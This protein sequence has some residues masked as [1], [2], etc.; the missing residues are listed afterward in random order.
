MENMFTEM[1]KLID[2]LEGLAIELRKKSRKERE[3]AVHVDVVVSN[4]KLL[5]DVLKK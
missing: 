5:M 2:E 1:R 4:M 3:K